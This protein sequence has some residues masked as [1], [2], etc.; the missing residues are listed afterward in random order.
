MGSLL[1]I[2]PELT[3]ASQ[4]LETEP[5]KKIFTALQDYGG[6]VVEDAAWDCWYLI[7]ERGVAEEV[8]T[9]Y[10][11][12]LE[13]WDLDVPFRRDMQKIIG[14]LNVIDNNSPT[15]IGGGGT[16]RQAL[17]P[18]FGTE[19]GPIAPMRAGSSHRAHTA[20]LA[21]GHFRFDFGSPGKRTITVLDMHGSVVRKTTS[22]EHTIDIDT[23]VNRAG[24]YIVSI[25][26]G[27][28]ISAVRTV[29]H[30]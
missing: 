20:F 18:E 10:N 26:Y 6:Y 19:T 15:S 9:A 11:V 4:N 8:K 22:S 1:A 2:K 30:R 27:D 13:C 7:A 25:D 28:R 24:A 16:P 21:N 14:L 17:A 5:A 3:A 29:V 23:G 12:D